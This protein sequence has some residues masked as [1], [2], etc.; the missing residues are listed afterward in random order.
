MEP[1]PLFQFLGAA[2]V[3]G[4]TV[5]SAAIVV[6]LIIRYLKDPKDHPAGSV[7]AEYRA[8]QADVRRAWDAYRRDRD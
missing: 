3:V 6:E 5:L 2:V 1:S 4:M 7:L 8:H